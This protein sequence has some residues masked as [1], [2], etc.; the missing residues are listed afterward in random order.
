MREC[1]N[2]ECGWVGETDRYC[3]AVGPLCPECGEVTEPGLDPAVESLRTAI[4]EALAS[5][6][7][8]MVEGA[9]YT[10]RDALSRN[11]PA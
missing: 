7:C 6:E 10:L 1:C 4:E 9:V 8:G 2:G 5:L 3:G 11:N